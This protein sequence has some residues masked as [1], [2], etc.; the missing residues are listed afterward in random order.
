MQLYSHLVDDYLERHAV[1]EDNTSN[2]NWEKIFDVIQKSFTVQKH[3]DFFKWLQGSVSQIL[4]HDVL[5]AAWGDF[6]SGDLNFD[7]S[8]NIEDISTQ[9]LID[10]PGVFAYLMSNLHQRWV[11]NGNKWFRIN[12]FDAEGINAQSPTQFTSKLVGMNSLLVYG[13]K[14]TRGKNDCIYVFFD[15]AREF[16]VQHSVL[17]LLMPHVD[18]ALRRV[19]YIVNSSTEV[20][21]I[22]DLNLGGLS[23]REH[24][25]LHWVKTGK[26][27]FEI[28]LILS[29]S[30]NT[31]KNHLK[32]IF[33]KLDVSCRAQAAAKFPQQKA[34]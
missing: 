30:P 34:I 19:E 2:Q 33:Q 25:I 14:D 11:D 7:V 23:D 21:M 4:P 8:S 15:K 22:E 1:L 29:I 5:V 20:E 27:N 3:V 10:A 26:T 9:K 24:E 18:A 31:V 16:Q 12:Y 6:S 13:V 32:R 17:G 28:G